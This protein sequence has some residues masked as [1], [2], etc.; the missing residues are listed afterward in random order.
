MYKEIFYKIHVS[1]LNKNTFYSS[2]WYG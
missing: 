2:R 1:E